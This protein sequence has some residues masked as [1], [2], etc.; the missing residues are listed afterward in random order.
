MRKLFI[1]SSFLL[2]CCMLYAQNEWVNWN[3]ANGGISFKNG[4][5]QQFNGVPKNL[6]FPDYTGQR[7]FSYA[8]P[9]TGSLLFLTDGQNIWNKNYRTVLYPPGDNLIS[10]DSDYYKV[11]IVPFSNAPNKFY[12]FHMY[13]AKGIVSERESGTPKGCNG[14]APV[15]N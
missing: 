12:L 4:T 9:T 11:Q 5:G 15:Y 1:I 6:Q 14:D 3:S 2:T 13:S 10:C 8:D 7:S